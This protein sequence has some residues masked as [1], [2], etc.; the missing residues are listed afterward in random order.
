M[1]KGR[2]LKSKTILERKP[3]LK[4]CPNHYEDNIFPNRFWDS[5]KVKDGGNGTAISDGRGWY[6][7]KEK[8]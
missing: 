6:K 2:K 7:P 1:K 4:L 8:K 3:K 5:A